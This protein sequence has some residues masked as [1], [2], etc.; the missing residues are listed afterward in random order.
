MLAAD[1]GEQGAAQVDRP[2]RLALYI[3]PPSHH[4]LQDRLFGPDDPRWGGD[5]VLAR[6]RYLR[7]VLSANGVSVHTADYL[8]EAA[9]GGPPK[10]YVSLGMQDRY[11]AVARRGDTLVSTFFVM[12][13]PV[14]EPRIFRKLRDASRYFKRFVSFT[15]GESLEPFVG[16]RLNM[17]VFRWP[18]SRDTIYEDIWPRTDRKLLV[19]INMNKLPRLYWH[20][21][22]TERMRAVEFFSRAQEIDLYGYGWSRPSSRMGR[23]WVPWTF[24]RIHTSALHQWHRVRPDPMLVAARRVYRGIA[25]PK[26]EVL[27]GYTFALC[28]ENMV[29]KGWVT[30]KIFECFAA[31]TIPIYWGAPDVQDYIPPE[32]FIDMRNFVGYEELRQF[33]KSMS[34]H[35]IM[36]YKRSAR[37]F[38][39]S[40][41]FRPF[42]KQALAELFLRIIAEDAPT[43]LTTAAAS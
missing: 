21:L 2:P 23:T 36:R 14:V 42:T 8:D 41:A 40:P 5:D 32:C 38:M 9:S 4:F 7:N 34:A 20:E 16:A 15:N 24:R 27:G 28:F 19:M 29:L 13:A 37:D 12:E 43:S 26:A 18:V 10:I 35:E 3:D 39:E 22:Y 25:H 30:E 11:R 1:S 6:F 33:L 17:E 31:G